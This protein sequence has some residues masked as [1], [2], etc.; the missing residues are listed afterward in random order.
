MTRR[1]VLRK[2]AREDV[3]SAATW[4]DDQE[5]G[6][7]KDFVTEARQLF[8]Q[9]A[10]HPARFRP[11]NPEVR[12]ASLHRFPYAVYFSVEPEE[13]VILAVIHKRRHPDT[14]RQRLEP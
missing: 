4:Y 11:V 12:Q 7:G 5:P 6:L 3:A 9:I 2:E 10:E 8:R 13:I 14:W 1:L